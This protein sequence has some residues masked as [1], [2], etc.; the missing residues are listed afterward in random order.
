MLPLKM[1]AAAS[2]ALDDYHV[3]GGTEGVP[4]VLLGHEAHPFEDWEP[5]FTFGP[6]NPALFCLVGSKSRLAPAEVWEAIGSH[7]SLRRPMT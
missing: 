5:P 7:I 6:D 2:G 1:P 4:Q 3:E